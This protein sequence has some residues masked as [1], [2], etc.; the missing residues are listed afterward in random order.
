MNNLSREGI[1]VNQ[2]TNIK[3]VDRVNTSEEKIVSLQSILIRNGE[4]IGVTGK[5][6]D[7]VIR[8]YLR[9]YYFIY[10]A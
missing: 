7:N 3:V 2:H 1:L 4:I 6:Q 5:D 10:Y 9:G 8:E